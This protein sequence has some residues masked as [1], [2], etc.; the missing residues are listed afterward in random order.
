VELLDPHS[1]LKLMLL[2][3]FSQSFCALSL[4]TFMEQLCMNGEFK[5]IMALQKYPKSE[6]QFTLR[7]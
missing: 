5:G 4:L 2:L 6:C 1:E 7:D 3:L